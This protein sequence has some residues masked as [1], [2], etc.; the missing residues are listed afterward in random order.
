MTFRFIRRSTDVVRL[1]SSL[2]KSPFHWAVL[3]T[4]AM[5]CLWSG[6]TPHHSQVES[7]LP[8]VSRT[9]TAAEGERPLRMT[10]VE[11]PLEE[12]AK[13]PRIATVLDQSEL[14]EI[15]IIYTQIDRDDQQNPR[16]TT[17]RLGADDSRYFYPAST[18]KMPL[19]FLALEKINRIRSE[20]N[21]DLSRETSYRLES[22]RPDQTEWSV[23]LKAPQS[24]PSIAQDIRAIFAVSDNDAYNHLYEF[25]GREYINATLRDKG[26]AKTGIVHRFYSTVLNQR[27]TQPISFYGPNGDVFEEPEKSDQR[28]W[29]NPQ[30]RTRKGTGFMDGR[31]ELIHEPFDFTGKNWFSLGD[32][33]RML[34]AVLFPDAMPSQGR[35]DI[36]NDDLRFLHQS[37]GLFPREFSYPKYNADD[38][39]DSYVKF[40]VMGDEKKTQ[41]H[42]LRIFNKVGEAYG[43]LTDTAYVVD[44]EDKVEF[45]LAATILCNRDGIF[46]DDQYDYESVGFPFLASLGK[47]VLDYERK[48]T[49]AVL[50]DLSYWQEVLEVD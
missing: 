1:A 41:E 3:C 2:S 9:A 40:F 46:N 16:F 6:L 26:Y 33:E 31:G 45:V 42:S 7:F 35:F 22:E 37:M 8:I 5:G 19:A 36:A 34:R 43:T 47:V 48:R 32:M 25:L 27:I 28:D 21:L 39:W 24:K 49:R 15:Q 50:P 18:V 44:F 38:Y 13:D 17:W 4:V 14:F 11:N 30:Q 20:G 23:D 10:H 12:L 29:Q